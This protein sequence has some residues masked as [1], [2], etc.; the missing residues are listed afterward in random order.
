LQIPQQQGHAYAWMIGEGR[1]YSAATT[2]IDNSFAHSSNSPELRVKGQRIQRVMEQYLEY[3]LT[4]KA[5][6]VTKFTQK[7][8][9]DQNIFATKYGRIEQN[10]DLRVYLLDIGLRYR[11]FIKEDR[12]AA[13]FAEFLPGELTS[14][15]LGKHFDKSPLQVTLGYAYGRNLPLQL[16][17]YVELVAKIHIYPNLSSWSPSFHLKGGID[18]NKKLRLEMDIL[19]IHKHYE[20]FYQPY[21]TLAIHKILSSNKIPLHKKNIIS[22]ALQ[23]DKKSLFENCLTNTEVKLTYKWKIRHQIQLGL[24]ITGDHGRITG[25]ENGFIRYIYHF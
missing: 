17:N 25:H 19:H 14:S 9:A 1:T 20:L 15:A 16:N 24:V 8:M 3:G 23:Q 13:I 7:E 6:L 5:T 21:H 11:H 4:P 22:Q 12:A 18:L 10:Y 2:Y